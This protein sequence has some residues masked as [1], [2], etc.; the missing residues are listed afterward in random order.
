MHLT[1]YLPPLD[2]PVKDQCHSRFISNVLMQASQVPVL[3]TYLA[4]SSTIA[5]EKLFRRLKTQLHNNFDLPYSGK[6]TQD[7]QWQ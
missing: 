2:H 4:S 5:L 6:L 3:G 1:S 7:E